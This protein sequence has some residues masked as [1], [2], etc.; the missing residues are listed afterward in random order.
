MAWTTQVAASWGKAQNDWKITESREIFPEKESLERAWEDQERIE[1]DFKDTPECKALLSIIPSSLNIGDQENPLLTNVS[2]FER[3][4][5]NYVNLKRSASWI[6]WTFE[7]YSEEYLWW[8]KITDVSPESQDNLILK[9]AIIES[10]NDPSIIAL[11]PEDSHNLTDAIFERL[12]VEIKYNNEWDIETN[13]KQVSF[14]DDPAYPILTRL[15]KEWILSQEDFTLLDTIY[16][17]EGSFH[18]I[19]EISNYQVIQDYLTLALSNQAWSQEKNKE[20][21][22][23]DFP[24]SDIEISS[25]MTFDEQLL[26]RANELASNNYISITKNDWS[27][28][29]QA[30]MSLAIEVAS[31]KLLQW[32][33]SINKSTEVF[34]KAISHIESG[35]ID[36]QQQGL[37]TLIYL[38]WISAWK[39]GQRDKMNRTKIEKLLVKNHEEWEKKQLEKA[40]N[41]AEIRAAEK[42]DREGELAW[43]DITKEA[44]NDSSY[45]QASTSP[46][47][48]WNKLVESPNTNTEYSKKVD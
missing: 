30:D 41:L 43:I 10:C 26:T 6:E 47:Q 17:K 1:E 21:F 24:E 44:A 37:A 36:L 28:D 35:N 4:V 33:Y 23:K 38:K 13:E 18:D 25:W 22:I 45:Q 39:F 32:N 3:I 40:Q 16:A 29:R 7:K 15:L 48:T 11:E 2:L 42:Q 14:I 19:K 5:V 20:A 9:L 27:I 12:P 34:K 31:K 46:L 8:H